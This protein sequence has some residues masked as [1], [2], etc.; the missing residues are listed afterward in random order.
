MAHPSMRGNTRSTSCVRCSASSMSR[1]NPRPKSPKG[2]WVGSKTGGSSLSHNLARPWT[3]SYRSDWPKNAD[4]RDS[5]WWIKW[6]RHSQGRRTVGSSWTVGGSCQW[7]PPKRLWAKSLY[8]RWCH[9][10]SLSIRGIRRLKNWELGWSLS[11]GSSL[12]IWRRQS[13]RV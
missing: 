1:R 12:V 9:F 10:G 5:T 8:W 7:L 13:S 2:T 4:S 6:C 3:Y 11:W